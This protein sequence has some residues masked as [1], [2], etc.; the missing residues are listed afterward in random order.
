M[1]AGKTGTAQVR[2]IEGAQRGQSGAW[3]FRDHGLFICFAPVE[4]P[5]YAAAVV[6]EHGL[7]G[8]RA[9]AP[10]AKDFLTYLYDPEKA[11]AALLALEAEWGGDINARM[12]TE[13]AQWK[14]THAL[15]DSPSPR[16]AVETASN[17]QAAANEAASNAA[18]TN[19]T[20]AEPAKAE[21][22]D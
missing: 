12:A 5:R 17:A 6:I 11:M 13:R 15:A 18:S 9:A 2:K 7:G 20:A 16:P 4:Q 8:A 3:K 19:A 14:A 21:G 1:M 22:E 10:V